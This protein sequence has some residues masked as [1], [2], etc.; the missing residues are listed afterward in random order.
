MKVLHFH[1][2]SNTQKRKKDQ[3]DIVRL[4]IMLSSC[5]QRIRSILIILEDQI[6]MHVYILYITYIKWEKKLLISKK[7][8]CGN[9]PNWRIKNGRIWSHH[10]QQRFQFIFHTPKY[11]IFYLINIGMISPSNN[12]TKF[13][14]QFDSIIHYIRNKQHRRQ[15]WVTRVVHNDKAI[16]LI[17]TTI[18]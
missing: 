9:I 10:N 5:D 14:V 15:R 16:S 17:T 2:K 12:Q 8:M 6:N 18:S 7:C 3:P 1:L 13:M 4:H 11:L